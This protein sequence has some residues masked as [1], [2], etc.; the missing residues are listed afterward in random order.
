M[1]DALK[2]IFDVSHEKQMLVDF[3][4]QNDKINRMRIETEK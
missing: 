3:W 2:K 4:I 1:T